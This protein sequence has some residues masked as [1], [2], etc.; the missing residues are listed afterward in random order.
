[1]IACKSTPNAPFPGATGIHSY[2]IDEGETGIFGTMAAVDPDETNVT[3]GIIDGTGQGY[4][5]IDASTG[6]V[7]PGQVVNAQDSEG[8][9]EPHIL[10]IRAENGNLMWR[11]S[12]A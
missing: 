1:M 8:S 6:E 7:T 10:V 12:I 2:Q 9:E 3:Y 11:V 4:F 5:N